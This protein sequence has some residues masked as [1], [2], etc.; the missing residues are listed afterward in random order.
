MGTVP[1]Q[2]LGIAKKK[3]KKIWTS[4]SR[5]NFLFSPVTEPSLRAEA[6]SKLDGQERE[7]G[8]QTTALN[9][10]CEAH[11]STKLPLFAVSDKLFLYFLHI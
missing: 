7:E 5:T 2:T 10:S 8:K 6:H 1:L 11:F 9:S 4:V 3:I